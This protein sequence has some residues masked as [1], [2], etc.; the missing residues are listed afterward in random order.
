L[1]E[2]IKAMPDLSSPP[3]PLRI[4]LVDDHEVVRVGLRSLLESYQDFIIAGEAEGCAETLAI[5]GKIRPDLILL[6]LRLRDGNGCD[7]CPALQKLVPG[8]KILILTSYL[9]EQSLLDAMNAGADGY[10]L[11]E[12]DASILAETIRTV[13]AG[14]SAYDEA[15]VKR[16]LQR[17]ESFPLNREE[18][19][20]IARELSHREW[21]M[22]R[23]ISL[24]RTNRQIAADLGMNENTLK[25][26]VSAL[27]TKLGVARRAEAAAFY[28]KYLARLEKTSK[29]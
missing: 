13:C 18:A 3:L 5:V 11:K 19:A 26:A 20:T 12:V 21:D 17:D 9:N 28:V 22:L 16:V 10:V 1:K 29:V 14:G 7:L 4:L 27:L 25:N 6:D 24:G 15:M 8:V 23:S 2:S